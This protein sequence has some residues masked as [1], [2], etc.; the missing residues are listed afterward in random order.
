MI[1]SHTVTPLSLHFTLIAIQI[2]N[3]NTTQSHAISYTNG[4]INLKTN[5]Y[6]KKILFSLF[7]LKHEKKTRGKNVIEHSLTVVFAYTVGYTLD[8]QKFFSQEAISK[9]SL[10]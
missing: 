4:F 5:S 10:L 7:S 9:L 3:C 8:I 6:Y 1:G 2:I